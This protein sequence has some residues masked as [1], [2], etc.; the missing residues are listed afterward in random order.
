LE[1]TSHFPPAWHE[2][3][4]TFF[5]PF[6]LPPFGIIGPLLISQDGLGLL[7]VRMLP[8]RPIKRNFLSPVYDGCSPPFV[9]A[10]FPVVPPVLRTLSSFLCF[11]RQVLGIN[12]FPP[13][14]PR[15]FFPLLPRFQNPPPVSLLTN[16][17]IFSLVLFP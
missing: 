8:L 13:L 6:L 4:D 17:D 9:D 10:G 5:L 12:C 7:T 16:S 14:I 2:P 15:C 11:Q 1:Q 3:L